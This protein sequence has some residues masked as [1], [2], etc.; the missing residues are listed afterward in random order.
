MVTTY[1]NSTATKLAVAATAAAMVVGVLFTLASPRAEA[2]ALTQSQI[3]S[4]VSLLSSFGADATTIANVTASLNGQ[5][6]SGGSTGGSTSS[7]CPFTWTT[8][9]MT[10][11][12]STDVM[13]L[14][15]FLNSSSDTM[16]ATSGAGS[17]G[18]ESNYYGAKTAAAVTKFQEKYAAD[19]LTPVGLTKGTGK[20]LTSSRAKANML[21]ATAT[22]GTTGGTTNPSG[23]GLSVSSA[24]QPANGY[25]VSNASRVPF[26][27]FTVT[28]G[29]DGD[30]VLNNVVVQRVGLIARGAFTGVVLLDENGVILGST[31]T[32]N[33]NDQATIGDKVTIARGTSKTFTVA[34]S[35]GSMNSYNGQNGGLNLVSVN[36]SAS[37][38]GSLPIMGAMHTVNGTLSI[39]TATVDVSSFDPNT[40]RNKEVGS[41]GYVFS[42]VRVTAGSAEDVRLRS[43]RWNQSGSISLTDMSNLTVVIDGV[44]YPAVAS[45]DGDYVSASFGNGI[46]VAEGLSKD[47]YL[48]GDISG[49]NASSRTVQF[50]LENASDI[51]LTG[52]KYGY[53]IVPSAG[54][55]GSITT[56][57]E[58]T[59]GTPFFSGS[60][61]TVTGGAA[62]TI[63]RSNTVPAQNIAVN[64]PNQPLGG[65]DTNFRGE[66]VTIS[67]L[68]FDIASSTALTSAITNVTLV[69]KNGTVVAG[70]V[71]ATVSATKQTVV[72]TDSITFPV[73][74][75][76]YTLKGKIPSSASNGTIL[77]ASTTPSDTSNWTNPK[78]DITGDTITLSQGSFT[79]NSMT[80]KT[81][82]LT[83]SVSTNPAAQSITAGVQKFVFANYQ[84]DATA[85]GEDVRFSS[86]KLL[87]AGSISSS[88]ITNCQLWDGTTALN[89]GSNVVNNPTLSAD[90]TFTL[91]Q[92]FVVAKGTSKTISLACDI[93]GG[94]TGN[95]SWG[96]TNAAGTVV[97]TGVTSSVGVTD[98]INASAGQQ[99]TINN[100]SFTVQKDASS[101]SYAVV[102]G[103]STGVTLGVLKLR[104]TNE[105]QY[106]RQIRLQLSNAAS[107][108][109]SNF[110]GNSVNLYD[111]TTLVGTATFNGSATIATSTLIGNGLLLPKDT[112]KILTVKAD[113]STIGTSQAGTEGAL[114]AVNYDGDYA[115][116]SYTVG[117]ASGSNITSGSSSD[118]AVD[119]V[120]VFRSFPTLA[121]A[122]VPTNVLSNGTPALLRFTVTADAKGDVG[123]YKFTL[124]FATS[125][126]AQ[127]SAV[128]IFGYTDSGY[129][130]PVSGVT[131]GGQLM[132]SNATPGATTGL[133]DIYVQNSSAVA[134]PLQIPAGTTRYFEVRG[135]VSGASSSGATVQTQL[136]GDSAYPVM[137]ALMGNATGVGLNPIDADTNNDFLW[138]PNATG[139]ATTSANDWTNGYGLVGLPSSNMTPEV[140]SK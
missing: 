13:K 64:V 18:M 103:A 65:F 115:A 108:S 69:D 11:S 124:K 88:A 55:T 7:V 136:E 59:T 121:K 68:T 138:S 139:T 130:I 119:G 132:A 17:A 54:T 32:L 30:V 20:F 58:F 72:F 39:G 114:I 41:T 118:T 83:I 4:I 129:S 71:D 79:L 52:E 106:L 90:N 35:F 81:A 126:N 3:Q 28:A 9:L 86:I 62:T 77:T 74:L 44:S 99:M 140:L 137:S 76:T 123:V 31:K 127:I 49:S 109:G 67:G 45:S 78:G 46:M 57:S 125:G 94:A 93:A 70:P 85:S 117:N 97:V 80:V 19:I 112:D 26:T 60:V 51:Y 47:I 22:G 16:V 92:S 12:N 66:A 50:D 63:S 110:V 135:T 61:V 104:A 122:S 95:L 133:A 56:N 10:G 43:I 105:D 27:K 37:V 73:G 53:G 89:T 98:T 5:P 8:N 87:P 29:N 48:K 111:G 120:R 38:S 96:I 25:I 15:K 84:L 33:S 14:Q 2:A 24:A 128:N 107:S 6:T 23:T 134:N 131:S 40:A 34:G 21:C 91:D 100:G 36:T 113:L 116:G 101:P 42:G 1:K 102:S 75:N 82:A